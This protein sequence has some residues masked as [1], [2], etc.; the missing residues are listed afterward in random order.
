MTLINDQEKDAFFRDVEA[1]A[2]K[3]IWCALATVT[4]MKPE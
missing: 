1:A 4:I 2:K 3:A